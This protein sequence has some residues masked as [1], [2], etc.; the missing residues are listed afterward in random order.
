M[1]GDTLPKAR[2]W[3]LSQAANAPHSAVIVRHRRLVVEWY[4]DTTAN[5]QHPI[6]K[7]GC[8]L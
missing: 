3:I 5:T 4:K 6:W 2:A 7:Y 8:G 1:D